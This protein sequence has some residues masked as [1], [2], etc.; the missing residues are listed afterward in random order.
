MPKPRAFAEQF[1]DPPVD[2]AVETLPLA[3]VVETLQTTGRV[4]GF[5]QLRDALLTNWRSLASMGLP[6]TA[7]IKMI[8]ETD[9]HALFALLAEEKLGERDASK[10]KGLENFQEFLKGN[11]NIP[12]LGLDGKKEFVAEEETN[13]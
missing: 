12:V 11:T 9:R 5:E 13:G 2:A 8:L 3:N 4:A 7:I 10:Q 1:V 6:L